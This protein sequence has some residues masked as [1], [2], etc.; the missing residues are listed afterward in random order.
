MLYGMHFTFR[1][2]L[3]G[4]CFFGDIWLHLYHDKVERLEVKRPD[5]FA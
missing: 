1:D 3:D 4:A 5:K 2:K